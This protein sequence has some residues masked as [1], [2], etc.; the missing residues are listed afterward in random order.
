MGILNFENGF[1]GFGRGTR[2][3]ADVSPNNRRHPTREQFRRLLPVW[4]NVACAHGNKTEFDRCA[5]GEPLWE[6]FATTLV[7][8]CAFAQPCPWNRIGVDKKLSTSPKQG[9]RS[10]I[11]PLYSTCIVALNNLTLAEQ[12]EKG[13]LP[14]SGDDFRR[15]FLDSFKSL[16]LESEDLRVTV[17]KAFTCM[18]GHDLT[19]IH[20]VD[21][22]MWYS[23]LLAKTMPGRCLFMT[24]MV[25]WASALRIS[26]QEIR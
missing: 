26:S 2:V 17:M 11:D 6:A 5:T 7:A 13:A 18:T 10:W 20:P 1:C 19:T 25:T 21:T 15:L 4:K 12:E 3:G 22:T 8:D 14:T 24:Q 23:E 16:S 9:T